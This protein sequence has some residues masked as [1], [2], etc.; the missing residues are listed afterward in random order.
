MKKTD[1]SKFQQLSEQLESHKKFTTDDLSYIEKK[2]SE[3]DLKVQLNRK[4]VELFHSLKK[5]KKSNNTNEHIELGL[6]IASENFKAINLKQNLV[7]FYIKDIYK[8]IE[9][10]LNIMKQQNN[11]LSNIQKQHN[12]NTFE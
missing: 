5:N 6:Q 12:E 7:D 2:I 8:K 4:N 3:I 10:I 11:L 1:L 9:N